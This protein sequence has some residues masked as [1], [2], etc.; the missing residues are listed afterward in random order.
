L[1]GEQAVAAAIRNKI[2]KYFNILIA[3]A[4]ASGFESRLKIQHIC[5]KEKN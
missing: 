1:F 3:L 2:E 4:I 5:R